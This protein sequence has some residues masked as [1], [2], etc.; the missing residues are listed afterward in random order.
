MNKLGVYFLFCG[1]CDL[2]L[3]EFLFIFSVVLASSAALTGPNSPNASASSA[4]IG[5]SLT[6][7]LPDWSATLGI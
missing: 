5:W 2:T 4:L 1:A 6:S 7:P 3:T